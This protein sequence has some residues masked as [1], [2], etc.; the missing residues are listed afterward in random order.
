MSFDTEIF[1]SK[2]FSDLL[3][4][5]YENQKKKDRQIN[6][7]IADLKPLITN[8]SDAALLVPVIKDYMEVSVK[9]DEHL[10]KLAAVI[11]R[12]VSKTTEEGSSFLTDEEKDALLKEIKTIGESHEATESDELS[13][14]NT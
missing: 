8:I 3:K 9:N 6:L 12:M 4:D 13:K 1:G 7:L 14:D 10:V 5:I 11:Q 2:K